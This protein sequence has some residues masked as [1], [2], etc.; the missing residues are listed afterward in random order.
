MR[1]GVNSMSDLS[2]DG[3][4]S[5]WRTGRFDG[6]RRAPKLLFGRMFEDSAIERRAFPA[7]GR[8][9]CI[10]SAGCTA[11][12]LAQHGA[13]VTAVDINPSQ[14]AYVER[15]LS[16]GACELGSADRV[17]DVL[18]RAARCC[19]LRCETLVEFLELD[20][21]AEQVRFWRQRIDRPAL[22]RATRLLLSKK[23]LRRAYASSLLRAVPDSFADVLWSR[24]ERGIGM[25]PNR[26]NPYAWQLFLGGSL[27][28]IKEA[29]S[30]G[31]PM[32]LICDDAADYLSKC[33]TGIFNGITLSN[34][35]DGVE[36]AYA[37]RL[38]SA[39]SNA[40]EA[41]A[42]VVLRS[43]A[44]P[45]NREEDELAAADRSLLWGRIAVR[46]AEEIEEA[47]LP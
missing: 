15:R 32:K 44:E 33:S 34:I 29:N 21:P 4:Q 30:T 11:L 1:R 5:P 28:E 37:T 20:D 22:R 45:R 14:I 39:V 3:A 19:G 25:H 35:L 16:G 2:T 18:R 24:L 41:S 23:V 40:A 31:N 27:H 42:P 8:V 10:A 38:V 46:P 43:F 12:E 47:L 26:T 9:F 36:D 17:M 13:Q 6:G 7:A